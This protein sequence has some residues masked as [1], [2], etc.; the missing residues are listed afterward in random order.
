MSDEKGEMEASSFEKATIRNVGIVAHID[1]GKTTLTERILYLTH[2]INRMGEVH[3]GTTVT[4][5]TQQ[6]RE[7]GISINAAAVNCHWK[8]WRVNVVDTPGHIDFTAE[9]ERSLCVMDGI[10]AV[11]CAVKGVQAQSETVWRCAKRHKLPAIAFINK[12]DRVGANPEMVLKQMAE[13]LRA[14]P[15]PIQ[16]PIW[17]GND[18]AGA[19]DLLTGLPAFSI[20]STSPA[21]YEA[22]VCKAREYLVVCL[23]EIDDT[24]LQLYL[25]NREPSECELKAAIRKAVV[26]RQIVPVLFGSS[27]N[28]QGV[29]N[30]LEAIGLYLPSPED[31]KATMGGDCSCSHS[32]IVVCRV[33]DAPDGDGRIAYARIFKGEARAGQVFRNQRN[34]ELETVGEVLKIQANEV[35]TQSRA[36]EGDIVGLRGAWSKTRTGDCLFAPDAPRAEANARM[37]F[38]EPVVSINLEAQSHDKDK[39]LGF[40]LRKIAREDP[41]LRAKPVEGTLAWSVSGMGELHLDIVRER[42]VSDFGITTRAGLPQVE[43]RET[44]S[45]EATK[46]F[47]FE[48]HL[49]NGTVISASVEISVKPLPRGKG[50]KIDLTC[51]RNALEDNQL[52][53]VKQGIMNIVTAASAGFP[54]TDMKVTVLNA[55]SV[56][57]GATEPA[58]LSAASSAL[59][60]AI[61]KAGRCV[62]EPV[63]L[64][65]VN[66]PS[67]ALG[68]IIADLNARR[69]TVSQVD[70]MALGFARIVALAPLAE[71]FGYASSL[72]SMS[73]GRGEVVAELSSY[74]ARAKH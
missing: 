19:V 17:D 7:H 51:I 2:V 70:T 61:D 26:E 37:R 42:L 36:G 52:L 57:G 59:K 55:A 50:I 64:L 65:E 24:I 10:V 14:T 58:L 11:F 63:M 30:L 40:A 32:D 39:A 1:A 12:M 68:S 38:P 72:R 46:A 29:D 74:K 8:G 20:K 69:A 16:F 21:S 44:V 47:L 4:D 31:R 54:M 22:D 62:L 15:L 41:T 25:N 3:D 71:L 48:K 67:D 60:Q 27:L 53:A 49:P 5:W 9:V 43:Y 23:A 28:N 56:S 13:K 66:T 18:F 34:G 35:E 6:E 33:S 73:A 45:C